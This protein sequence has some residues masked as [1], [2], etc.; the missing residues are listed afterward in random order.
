MSLGGP[1]LSFSFSS[2]LSLLTLTY[3]RV[4]GV[5]VDVEGGQLE[6]QARSSGGG[7]LK[8]KHAFPRAVALHGT[9]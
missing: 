2:V 9:V 1:S 6:R 7:N 3:C 4:A 5:R 8:L